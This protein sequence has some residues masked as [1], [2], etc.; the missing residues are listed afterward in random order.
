[1]VR[2]FDR[3]QWSR[4]DLIERILNGPEEEIFEVKSPSFKMPEKARIFDSVV[5]DQCGEAARE[6]KIRLDHGRRL[7]LD[8]H[9]AYERVFL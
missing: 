7:C 2:P 6:D 5:C 3:D 9:E 4:E 1:V 8:C